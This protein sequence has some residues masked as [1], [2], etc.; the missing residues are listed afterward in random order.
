M[1]LPDH[2]TALSVLEKMRIIDGFGYKMS[3]IIGINGKVIAVYSVAGPGV[4][5]CFEFEFEY[6]LLKVE[7]K[8]NKALELVYCYI[9]LVVKVEECNKYSKY[10]LGTP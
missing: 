10:C 2:I 3:C 9:S 1:K 5:F 4:N 6:V 7:D 8:V